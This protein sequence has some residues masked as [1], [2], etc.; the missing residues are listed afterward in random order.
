[1]TLKP[2]RVRISWTKLRTVGL[3]SLAVTQF[4]GRSSFASMR[5]P[6]SQ[7]PKCPVTTTTP[8]PSATAPSMISAPRIV[9]WTGFGRGPH[10]SM[11][12]VIERA[13][14]AKTR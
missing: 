1:M 2:C 7:D 11:L 8:R 13:I 5:A 6:T 9:R 14:P 10:C 4:T 3:G 12:S